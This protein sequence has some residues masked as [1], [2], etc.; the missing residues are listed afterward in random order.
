VTRLGGAGV[1]GILAVLLACS[2]NPTHSQDGG[3]TSNADAFA[4]VTVCAQPWLL[5]GQAATELPV[6]VHD[7]DSTGNDVFSVTCTVHAVGGGF[8][9]SL[10][11]SDQGP[12]GGAVTITS[13]SGT[14]NVTTSGGSGISATLTG[15]HGVVAH[16]RNCTIT[17]TYL[18]Q[19]VPVN[20]SVFAGKI[21]GHLSCPT[22][23]LTMEG[24]A[25]DAS[26]GHCDAEADFLFENCN[27]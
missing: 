9:V 27:E 11:L 14:G 2:S 16:G 20:P 18:G 21:W 24:G 1:L 3:A 12:Q 6:T 19:P 7:G 4:Q 25:P 23:V 13:P 8:D 5:A 22:T 17:P 15:A 10:S 26:G